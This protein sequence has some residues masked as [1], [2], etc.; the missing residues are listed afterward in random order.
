MLI[1]VLLVLLYNHPGIKGTYHKLSVGYET[2]NIKPENM[3]RWSSI[4]LLLNHRLRRWPNS[5]PTLGQSLMISGNLSHTS[6]LL[7]YDR[8]AEF[9]F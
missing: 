4:G 1:Y 6:H 5:K 9:E 7:C 2:F 3:R 8:L